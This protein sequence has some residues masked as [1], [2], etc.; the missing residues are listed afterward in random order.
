MFDTGPR[1]TH[2]YRGKY[3]PVPAGGKAAAKNAK[4]GRQETAESNEEI[5]K[6]ATEGGQE[7]ES[8]P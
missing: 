1:P 8:S 6:G 5:R 4:E 3:A 7:P 2:H